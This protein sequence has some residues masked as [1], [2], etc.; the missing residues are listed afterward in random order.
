M[1]KGLLRILNGEPADE[2]VW[3]ADIT[4]WIAGRQQAG[5]AK[6]EWETEEGYL[7]LHRELGILPYSCQS[8]SA[9]DSTRSRR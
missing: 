2:I 8:W 3:T 6:A 9:P 1:L 4:Y 5:C 7:Q